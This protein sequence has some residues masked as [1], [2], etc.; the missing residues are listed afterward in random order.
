MPCFRA[1]V[2][3]TTT[4]VVITTSGNACAAQQLSTE[5]SAGLREPAPN[6]I[7]KFSTP[8]A[9]SVFK[10]KNL[11]REVMEPELL[12][13]V[14]P[15]E[16]KIIRTNY[17]ITRT[18][19]SDPGVVDVQPFKATELE[20]VGRRI[21]EATLTFWYEVPGEGQKVL[22]YFVQVINDRERHRLREA[23]YKETQSRINEL[24]PESKVFLIPI[25]DKLI[26]R[27]QVR[28]SRE[29]Q[30]ILQILGK[31][32]DNSP[33]QR[34]GGG[35][36]R[37]GGGFGGGFGGFGGGYGGGMGNGI[38]GGHAQRSS[39]YGSTHNQSY[40]SG[41]GGGRG[42]V[43]GGG[44]YQELAGINDDIGT[45]LNIG[46][47]NI[48]NQLKVAGEQQV[49]LKVRIAELVRNANRGSGADIQATFEQFNLSHLL[50][51]G[52]NISAIL[53]DPDISFFI[54]AIASHN[55]GKILA[56]PTLVTISGKP[57]N[58]L[59]GGQFA[60]PTT[61][62]IG[63]VGGLSTQFHGFGTSLS[64][65]PTIMDKDL[66]RLEVSPSFSTLNSDASVGGIPGLSQR[67]VDTTVDLREGQWLAIAGLIQDEQ[68][69][70]KARTP[71]ISDLPFLGGLFS[72][73]DTTRSETELIVLV[74]PQL[75][76]PLEE[77]QVPLLLP[78]MEVTDPTDDDF[79]FRRQTEGYR[80]FDF[81]STTSSE[82]QTHIN[83][84]KQSAKLDEIKA[85]L[86]PRVRRQLKVQQAYICGPS[87][88][89]K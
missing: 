70:Q 89:S 48:I 76:H 4:L 86:N 13:R 21:G 63:G 44:D 35:N 29:A 67:S 24:F 82:Y 80:G 23:K 34:G 33:G 53:E 14:K 20:I 58:F 62:G 18:S 7:Q 78:G 51:S 9:A 19:I 37:Q 6:Q 12:L 74:S 10:E 42:S 60:V 45:G 79:F 3:L 22:R 16:S 32:F 66:I 69:G 11:I 85:K 49:M 50:S 47:N 75:V 55:Y 39:G 43:G 72:T 8:A 30:Q 57:A 36:G 15:N 40:S 27:G 73:Q 65:T 54:R 41:G 17:P 88:F 31:T 46:A 68:G 61:V 59:A 26:V 38:G 81:R 5:L 64:F 28:D 84:Y 1:L 87:G 83:G 52:G 71:Y 56:E 25:E 77:E 2:L